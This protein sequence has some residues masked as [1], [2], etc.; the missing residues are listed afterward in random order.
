MA[1]SIECLTLDFGLGHDLTFHEFKPRVRAVKSLLG[2][3]SL[4]A[5]VSLPLLHS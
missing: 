3:L 2:I 1:Q 5:L 4:S